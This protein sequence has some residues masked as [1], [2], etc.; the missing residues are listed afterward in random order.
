MRHIFKCDNCKKYT[1]KE[2][3]SCGNKTSSPRPMKFSPIDKFTSY[4]RMAKTKE[5]EG[6]GLL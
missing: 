1:M 6:R 5:Y 2:I 3:C 4:R